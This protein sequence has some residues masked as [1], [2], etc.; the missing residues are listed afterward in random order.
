MERGGKEKIVEIKRAGETEG[1]RGDKF[2]ICIEHSHLFIIWP[3]FCKQW[4]R[5]AMSCLRDNF[6][7]VVFLKCGMDGHTGKGGEIITSNQ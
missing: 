7:H 6:H 2:I 5:H 4:I 1:E 3:T